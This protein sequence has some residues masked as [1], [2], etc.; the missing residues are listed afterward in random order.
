LLARCGI[1]AP[2]GVEDSSM[3]AYTLTIVVQNVSPVERSLMFAAILKAAKLR[4]VLR[5]IIH[6]PRVPDRRRPNFKLRG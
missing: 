3:L 2:E 1:R 6:S 5:V 4:L